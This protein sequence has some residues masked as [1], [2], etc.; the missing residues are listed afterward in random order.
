M[1]ADEAGPRSHTGRRRNEAARRAILDAIGAAI[2]AGASLD[3]L[4]IDRIAADA[5]VGRQ[6]IYRWWPSKGAVLAEAMTETA[7][8]LAPRPESG[9]LD[10]DLHRFLV[11]TFEVAGREPAAGLLRSVVAE[12]QRDAAT[13]AALAEFAA[14]RRAELAAIVEA[15]RGRGELDPAA[16]AELLAEQALGVLWYRLVVT[17]APVDGEVARRLA[18]VLVAQLR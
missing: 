14:A 1:A 8:R 3:Q 2:E 17:G 13:A 18:E 15:A 4:T 12:A 10:A 16:D 9:S 6:T 5:G 7:R 11:S